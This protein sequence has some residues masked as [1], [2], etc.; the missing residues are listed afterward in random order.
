MVDSVVPVCAIVAT[1]VVE[2]TVSILTRIV[3]VHLRDGNGSTQDQGMSPISFYNRFLI[4][5]TLELATAFDMT[6]RKVSVSD[7]ILKHQY[8][9]LHTLSCLRVLGGKCDMRYPSCFRWSGTMREW[10]SP[11]CWGKH[12]AQKQPQLLRGVKTLSP[13]SSTN[14]QPQNFVPYLI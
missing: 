1:R 12:C 14:Y 8:D 5:R 4:N 7:D 3:S 2:D 13:N 9:L 6:R 10:S 11:S